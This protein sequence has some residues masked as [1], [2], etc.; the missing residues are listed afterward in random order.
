MNFFFPNVAYADVDSFVSNVNELILNPLINV[1]FALAL[2]FFLYGVVEFLVN[3]DNEE[4]RTAGR[5][6]MLW[7]IVGLVIMFGVWFFMNLIV[8]SLDIE[9][10]DP[11]KGTVDLPES[12]L[13][14]PQ[15]GG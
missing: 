9:G 2:L 14:Y 13:T 12:D 1:L 6:H 11:E 8:D 3:Q 10:I 15:L 4:K 7:G 5:K